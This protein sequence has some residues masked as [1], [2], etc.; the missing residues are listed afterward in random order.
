MTDLRYHDGD[1]PL[2]GHLAAAAGP[3]PGV[4]VV[5]AWLGITDT[6]RARTDALAAA[7]YHA[8]AADMF[9]RPTEIDAGPRATVAPLIGDPPALRRRVAAALAALQ[10]RPGVSRTAAI[11]FCF[12]GTAVLELARAGAAVAGT[13]SF[14]GDLRTRLPAGPGAIAGPVLVL[15]GD[16][17]PLVPFDQVGA[18]LEEMRAA[19]AD[20]EIDVYSGAR[21]SFTGEGSLGSDRTPEAVLHPQA[22]ARSWRAALAFLDEVLGAADPADGRVTTAAASPGGRRPR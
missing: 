10:D 22:N 8:L 6:I 4:L 20:F 11:G 12:G 7:G 14:H 17:D 15:T 13:V 16:A 3:A 2:T 5:P 19:G 1:L 18:F 21:H 9:G